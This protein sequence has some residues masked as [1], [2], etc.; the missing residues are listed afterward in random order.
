MRPAFSDVLDALVQRGFKYVQRDTDGRF[1]VRGALHAGNQL[2]PCDAALDPTGFKIPNIY[3]LERPAG[4]PAVTPHLFANGFLCYLASGTVVI[5][6]FDPIGQ[7]LACLDAAGEVLSKVL[8]GELVEDLADDFYLYW[9]GHPCFVDTQERQLGKHKT[10]TAKLGDTLIPVVTD[11]QAR[12]MKKLA[13]M[14]LELADPTLLTTRVKT[15]ARPTPSTKA[16]PPKNVKDV[17]AWQVVLDS[18]CRDKIA[19]ALKKGRTGKHN[20]H[21]ILVESPTM[22]YGFSVYYTRTAQRN[23]FRQHPLPPLSEESVITANVIRIDDR[24]L[25]ERNVPGLK[26]LAGKLIAV[27][28][29]GTIGGY[30][31]DALVK[32][33]AGTSG[34]LLTLVDFDEF[35]PQNVGRHRLGFPHILQ[36]KA[37]ALADELQRLAPGVHIRALPVDVTTA[38]LGRIDLLV[39]A[40]GEE[41]LGHWLSARYS[42]TT[43]MLSVW[44]EGP[45][46]AVRAL[47]RT[48]PAGACHR[49]LSDA[50]RT[51]SFRSVKGTMP[52]QMAGQGCEGLYVPF[53]ASVSLQA[54]SLGAEMVLDWANGKVSPA[55][56]TRVVDAKFELATPDCDPPPTERCPACSQ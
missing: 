44:I 10:F 47:L 17:L 31:A 9:N 20:G 45:G 21:L 2:Y 54:A 56:R 52:R 49:C 28:G 39:N 55:L 5:D 12:T 3:L 7:T 36:N 48:T 1:R 13:A 18:N 33:G 14:G 4:L 19:Y 35:R 42:A 37:S 40:T 50:I 29:C 43:P 25:A 11:D 6:I 16:W 30:L 46:T 41:A 34:G 8:A 23:G 15:S 32:A 24:Y 38:E 26:T 51:G 22:T 53:P 27:V